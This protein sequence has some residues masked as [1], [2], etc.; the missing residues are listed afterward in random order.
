LTTAGGSTFCTFKYSDY[1][2]EAPL[3]SQIGGMTEAHFEISSDIRAFARLSYSHRDAQ[4]IAAPAPNDFGQIIV[5][6]TVAGTFGLPNYTPGNPIDVVFRTVSLGT[7]NTEV[8][9]DAFGGVAGATMQLPHDFA[10]D[11]TLSYMLTKNDLEGTSGF[12]RSDILTSLV[13]SGAYNP[14]VATNPGSLTSAAYQPFEKTQAVNTG[15]E[16]KISGDV[17]ETGAG[18]ISI[19]AGTLT[20]FSSYSDALDDYSIQ[21]LVVGNSGSAGAGHR[22]AEAV[23]AE[24]SIPVIKKTLEFQAAARY[25]HYSDFGST[26]NPRLG[27]LYHALPS[28]LLR[29]SVGTGFRAPLLA[30]LYRGQSQSADTFIDYVACAKNGGADCQAQ[31]YDVTSGGNPNLKQET[32]VSYGF[33]ALYEP[34]PVFNVSTDWFFTNITNVPGLDLNDMTQAQQNGV[35]PADY[36]VIVTR[37]PTTN[38]ITNVIAPEQNLSSKQIFGVDISASY[39]FLSKFKLTTDQNQL[40]FYKEEGFPGAGLVNKL[41]WYG[42]PSWRNATILS[43]TVA[44]NQLAGIAIRTIPK[45]LTLDR[46]SSITSLTTIDLSYNIRLG[47]FGDFN[48]TLINLLNSSPPIDPSQPTAPVNYSLYDPNGRQ[49]V[50]SYKKLF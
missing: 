13:T 1:S 36:G 28:L 10:L 45:Q 43:Y 14:F 20:N 3:I 40:F 18:P 34:L 31:Q 7:R 16:A 50:L 41:G 38:E 23:Y 39:T 32:A 6:A 47:A 17:V 42:N 22:L 21:G 25:D 24:G 33:G 11:V 19:A 49:I 12:A 46:S 37:D 5:P 8:K 9:S 44:D 15:I 2:E 4:T 48:A 26:V 35:N 29:A 27:V 30:D